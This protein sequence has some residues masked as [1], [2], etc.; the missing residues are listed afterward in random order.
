LPA[1][2]DLRGWRAKIGDGDGLQQEGSAGEKRRR[3]A[4]STHCA[5]V[6]VRNV[7]G[8]CL[9]GLERNGFAA[10]PPSAKA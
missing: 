9:S 6:K 1:R 5:A 2:D 8:T 4:A 10:T 3:A 7:I